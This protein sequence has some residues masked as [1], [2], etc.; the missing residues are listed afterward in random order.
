MG[1]DITGEPAH[2][3]LL[4]GLVREA[5]HW[6][7]FLPLF[8]AGFR[9]ATVRAADLPGCGTQHGVT[10]P[11][12]VSQLLAHVR[13]E[14]L[15]LR[16]GTPEANRP[17][18]L[19]GISLGAMVLC[20]WLREHPG[21]V[22]GAVLINSS[23]A[24]LSRPWQRLRPVGGLRLA[25][26]ALARDLAA[27]ERHIYRATSARRERENMVVPGWVELA[28]THPVSRANARTLLTA[29][30]QFRLGTVVEPPPT[31]VLAA[32][33]DR[34]VHPRC[35]RA[36]AAALGSELRLHP[37]AGHDLPLDEPE[38]VVS[39]VQGWQ[40]ALQARGAGPQRAAASANP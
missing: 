16:A 11:A 27:R 22:A 21:E 6:G 15:R 13:N 25:R 2:W 17:I 24:D 38:W 7:R 36:L 4:R 28:R 39:E 31:L 1:A 9:E 29:A 5:G 33:G 18:W 20:Q 35:S 32:A 3:L 30:N 12:G 10:A 23:A 34:L 40:A 14:D 26:A 8:R 37:T 19:L